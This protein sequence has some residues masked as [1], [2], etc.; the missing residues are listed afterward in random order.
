MQRLARTAL[1]VFNDVIVRKASEFDMPLIDLRAVCSAAD[2]YANPIEPSAIGGLKI[3]HAI[4]RLALG[5]DFRV[6]SAS[7]Y[8]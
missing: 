7:I 3:A 6:R 2:D 4:A 5:H 8:V 1:M